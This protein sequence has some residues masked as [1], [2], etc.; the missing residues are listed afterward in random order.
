M[1]K[2]NNNFRTY[3]CYAYYAS[4]E[5]NKTW[6]KGEIIAF[7][8]LETNDGNCFSV[9]TYKYTVP[10]TGIYLVCFG[11]FT[12]DTTCT[13]LDS[14][15]SIL[16]NNVIEFMTIGNRG[17]TPCGALYASAGDTIFAKNNGTNALNFY[18]AKNHN[19][20]TVTRLV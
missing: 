20:F 5:G 12:N 4:D 2:L 11:F 6:A 3:H 16:R 13:A 15:P 8:S 17:Q 19:W 14:R 1:N 9:S 10:V 7:N 18:A